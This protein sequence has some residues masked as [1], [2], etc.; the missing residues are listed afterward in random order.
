M[1]VIENLKS[2]LRKHRIKFYTILAG[3]I[4]PAKMA[5]FMEVEVF[6][7]VACPENSIIDSKEFY[8]P[9]VTPLEMLLA[10]QH[11]SNV[12]SG[13]STEFNNFLTKSNREIESQGIQITFF[14][15]FDT[16]EFLSSFSKIYFYFLETDQESDI[17]HYSLVTGKLVSNIKLE[18]YE[19]IDDGH[20]SSNMQVSVKDANNKV[21][22]KMGSSSFIHMSNR[23]FQGL[24]IDVEDKKPSVLTDGRSGIAKGYTNEK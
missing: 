11:D 3:K 6:V 1:K 18:T 21:A 2:V 5:N 24:H 9:V 20:D 19:N 10:L 14:F 4:N 16:L 23:S 8:Q 22:L 15:L 7:T 12:Y 13:Y 17:P